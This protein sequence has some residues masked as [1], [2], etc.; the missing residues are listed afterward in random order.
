VFVWLNFGWTSGVNCQRINQY[1]SVSILSLAHNGRGYE[2]LR[3]EA[4]K[5]KLKIKVNMEKIV[6]KIR[7]GKQWL[8]SFVMVRTFLLSSK[9]R[10]NYLIMKNASMFLGLQNLAKKYDND[11]DVRTAM[12][13]SSESYDYLGN[14]ALYC[15][16]KGLDQ[17]KWL[18]MYAP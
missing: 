14:F 8:I 15:N 10:Q 11:G 2:P 16:V 6:E 4:N 17:V 12:L 5:V 13:I 9:K 7:Q 1:W 18:K 3:F